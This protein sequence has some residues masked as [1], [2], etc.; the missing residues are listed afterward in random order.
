M[1]AS[2]RVANGPG[3]EPMGLGAAVAVEGLAGC[4]DPAQSAG[5]IDMDSVLSSPGHARWPW[6]EEQLGAVAQAVRAEV[7]RALEEE[8]RV[9]SGSPRAALQWCLRGL[10]WLCCGRDVRGRGKP[11]GCRS[12]RRRTWRPWWRRPKRSSSG[13][14][15]NRRGRR[16]RR[17]AGRS[18]FLLAYVPPATPV[19]LPVATALTSSSCPSLSGLSGC[20][21][22]LPCPVCLSGQLRLEGGVA[23]DGEGWRLG[24]QTAGLAAEELRCRLAAAFEV[25]GW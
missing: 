4:G 9:R 11:S 21:A 3:A 16:V 15:T 6:D 17:R 19:L 1:A 24:P 23:C 25:W 10:Q 22:A 14:S 13:S 12:T 5:V 2:Q 7:Y 20:E 8:L 18:R